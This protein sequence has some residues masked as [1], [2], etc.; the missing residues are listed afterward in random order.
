[1]RIMAFGPH[2]DDIEILCGGTLAKYAAQGH[3][4]AI[5]VMTRGDVGSP[6]LPRETIAK[7]REGEARA[8]AE[9]VGAEF[10]W[11]GYDDEFLYD[12]PDVRRHVIDVIRQFQPDIVLCPDKEH[13]YHPDHVR[14]GQIV[15]DTHVMA[16]VPNIVTRHGVTSRIHDIWY[17]DTISG[18]D[19]RPEFY[20]DISEHWETKARM[21][22]CHESQ[23]AWLVAQYGK[24][25]TY[26]AETQS[27]FRGFQTGCEFAECFRRARTFPATVPQEDLL[28]G[29]RAASRRPD[30]STAAVGDGRE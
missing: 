19:F 16:T 20:V 15:W 24:T 7:I 25:A 8:A 1:M 5:A 26:Y 10:F 30:L 6:T 14:T 11:M 29:T 18:I 12:S 28:P 21:V 9:L 3:A 17:Y 23:S 22:E 13:D 27:R 4:V 2:P